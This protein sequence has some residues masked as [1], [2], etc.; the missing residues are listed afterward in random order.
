MM[1]TTTM[2]EVDMTICCLVMAF[3]LLIH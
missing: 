3:L 2:F 1:K